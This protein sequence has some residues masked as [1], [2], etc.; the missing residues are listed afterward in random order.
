MGQRH[1]AYRYQALREAYRLSAR[2]IHDLAMPGQAIKLLESAAS[3]HEDGI[4]TSNRCSKLLSR[5]WM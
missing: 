3:Y 1:V 5:R 4:V 2:Y